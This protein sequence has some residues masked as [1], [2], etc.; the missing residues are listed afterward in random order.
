MATFLNCGKHTTISGGM[1]MASNIKSILDLVF[2]FTPAR[3]VGAGMSSALW[4]TP[5]RANTP[6][7]P[8]SA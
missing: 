1:Q 2:Q 4:L 5:P 6:E 8:F 7:C 3:G